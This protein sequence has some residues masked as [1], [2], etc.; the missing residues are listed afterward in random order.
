MQ[1][2]PYLHK[3]AYVVFAL[4]VL[5][6]GWRTL[7]GVASWA[8]HATSWIALQ[9]AGIFVAASFYGLLE[10]WVAVPGTTAGWWPFPPPALPPAGSLA[11]QYDSP[12][13]GA[14][15]PPDIE[16]PPTPFRLNKN[17]KPAV[18]PPWA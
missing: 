15:P 5:L 10:G 1:P 13:A 4:A 11:V 18:P 7:S 16:Q 8:W 2:R 12:T 17:T 14:P 6:I 3:T 9:G